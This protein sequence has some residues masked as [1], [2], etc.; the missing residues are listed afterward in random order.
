MSAGTG[1]DE[2]VDGRRRGRIESAMKTAEREWDN[3]RASLEMCGDVKRFSARDFMVGV[4][5]EDLIT[6]KPL[7][8]PTKSVD[9]NS[10]TYYPMYLVKNLIE[11]D[12]HM[13]ERGYHTPQAL[14]CHIELA[15]G[16][17]SDLG[18]KGTLAMGFACGYAVARTGWTAEKGLRREREFFL[19]A[20][21]GSSERN[22]DWNFRWH[23][24]KVK[25]KKIFDR[26]L[27]W[28]KD[29]RLHETETAEERKIRPPL[30]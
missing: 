22:R 9:T 15:T 20:F 2:L 28:Q 23:S 1:L 30:V 17:V 7:Y 13:P 24:T 10:P 3:I 12:R 4:M 14:Y 21:F 25:M 8:S 6:K 27:A 5:E 19:D 16:A 11:M 29:G 18:L 26:F